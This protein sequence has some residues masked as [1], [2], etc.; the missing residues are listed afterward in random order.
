MSERRLLKQIEA[1]ASLRQSLAAIADDEDAL[2]D[3]I[4][5]QTDL[6]EMIESV[7]DSIAQDQELLDGIKARAEDMESRKSR[8]KGRVERKR[9][10][11]EQAMSVGEL[12][13]LELPECTLSLGKKPKGLI[14]ESEPDVPSE[15]W[16][17]QPPTLDKIAL[18]KD[19]RAGATVPGASLDNGG[20]SLTIRRK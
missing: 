19:L 3:T 12:R 8:L 5:G 2:R 7:I 4:E 11:I 15:Y 18:A 14:I 20:V 6:H 9:A 10:L 16:K 1:A 17:P 13:S